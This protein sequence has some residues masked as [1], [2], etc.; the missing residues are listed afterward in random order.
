[1]KKI[2]LLLLCAFSITGCTH[3]TGDP[4][5]PEGYTPKIV[6]TEHFSLTVWE[7][8]NIE[9]K[10]TLRFYITEDG[11]P[12]PDQNTALALAAKDPYQNIIVI[13]RPC[14][15]YKNKV[16][17]KSA[18]WREARYNPE[19]LEE[20]NELV[21]FLIRKHKATSSEFVTVKGGAPIAFYLAD[22]LG[23]TVRIITIADI[24]DVDAYTKE[25]DLPSMN[26]AYNPVDR[27]N[28]IAAIPQVH[29]VGDKDSITTRRMAERFV[30]RL[31]NPRF[32]IVKVVPDQGHD[33]WEEVT[34]DYYGIKPPKPKN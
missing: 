17:S 11:D 3:N 32:A 31:R 27:K 10:K 34:L 13:S 25:N 19:I 18:I 9:P 14:Q 16:C 20:M 30:A 1:M 2:L 15:Y 5:V 22:K 23:R 7:K 26:G 21:S 28:K 8:D 33:H 4:V 12:T 29:Y 24:L 6:E